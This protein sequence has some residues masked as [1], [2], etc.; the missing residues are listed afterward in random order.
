[1]FGSNYGLKFFL[2]R[3]LWVILFFLFNIS[4]MSLDNKQHAVNRNHL[5]AFSLDGQ[6]SSE[7][8]ATVIWLREGFFYLLARV[9]F[10][11]LHLP[12]IAYVMTVL[13]SL[14]W[15]YAVIWPS[16]S[17]PKRGYWARWSFICEMSLLA[18]CCIQKGND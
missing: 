18:W 9:G 12:N 16:F 2:S 5:E 15:N 4:L 1:M 13:F 8:L 10:N 17:A 11:Q 6:F 7:S 3:C 14:S